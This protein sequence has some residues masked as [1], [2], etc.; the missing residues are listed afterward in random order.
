MFYAASKLSA[1]HQD[2]GLDSSDI[3]ARA[4]P[5]NTILV[6]YRDY[7]HQSFVIHPSYEFSEATIA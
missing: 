4:M 7:L 3:G 2:V 6:F 1:P 5:S